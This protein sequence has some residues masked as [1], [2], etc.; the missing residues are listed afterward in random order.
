MILSNGNTVHTVVSDYQF[1]DKGGNGKLRIYE[2]NP[3]IN[4]VSVKTYSPYANTYETDTSSQFSLAVNLS[5]AAPFALVG[6]V[7]NVS[8]GTNACVSW[9]SLESNAEYEWYAE[10]FDGQNTT[11]GPIWSFTTKVPTVNTKSTYSPIAKAGMLG[12]R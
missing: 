8:S 10:V 1:R 11:N 12:S 7:S 3:S 5:S 9:P 2:F 4:N 6:E